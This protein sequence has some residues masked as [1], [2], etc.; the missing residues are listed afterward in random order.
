M[1]S[2]VAVAI[3][4]AMSCSSGAKDNAGNRPSNAATVPPTPADTPTPTPDDQG[5]YV[6]KLIGDLANALMKSDMD[7][8]DKILSN[9]YILVTDTGQIMTKPKGWR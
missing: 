6:R 5:E 4:A 7:A 1:A 2:L 9:E 3:V 8:L